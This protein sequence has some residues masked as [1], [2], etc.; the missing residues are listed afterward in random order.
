VTHEIVVII[1]Q[2]EGELP[3]CEHIIY[4]TIRY[5]RRVFN[6][7]SKDMSTQLYQLRTRRQKKI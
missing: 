7:D 5:D 2:P 6:A 3:S 1:S 4:D